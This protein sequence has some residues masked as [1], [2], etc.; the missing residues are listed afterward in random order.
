M[1][2][3]VYSYAA[4]LTMTEA[5]SCYDGHFYLSDWSSPTPIKPNPKRNGPIHTDCK[6]ICNVVSSVAEAEKCETF[7]NRKI[8]IGVRLDL[9]APQTTSETPQNVQFYKKMMCKLRH[10][11]QTFKNMG[12]EMELVDRQG[13]N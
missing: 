5:R 9:I 6:I 7:N 12:Y 2:L 3:Q 13:G 4:Y 10:E 11:T 8:A 1:I